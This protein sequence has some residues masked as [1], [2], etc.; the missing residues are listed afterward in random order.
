MPTAHK[1]NIPDGYGTVSSTIEWATVREQLESAK[2]Y[3]L[4]INRAPGSPHVIPIDGV[5][6]DDCWY[7]GG[8]PDTL[9]RRLV[10]DNPHVTIH[11]PDPWKVVIVDGA[12]SEVNPSE[13]V[14]QQLADISNHKYPDY[15][16]TYDPSTFATTMFLQPERALAWSSFPSD[17][18]RFSF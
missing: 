10:A 16:F 2:Q 15:G 5:W 7:Y 4:S 13:D 8:S 6:L 18:T 11:L 1:L 9:H 12:V 17:C 14:A 3:W